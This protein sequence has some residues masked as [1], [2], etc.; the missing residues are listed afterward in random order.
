MSAKRSKTVCRVLWFDE[1]GR[2]TKAPKR[3][4][5][6]KSLKPKLGA[7]RKATQKIRVDGGGVATVRYM[8]S[9]VAVRYIPPADVRAEAKKRKADKEYQQQYREWIKNVQRELAADANAQ[10][11]LMLSRKHAAIMEKELLRDRGRKG[12]RERAKSREIQKGMK[13]LS[14]SEL[15]QKLKRGNVYEKRAARAELKARGVQ[16]G[17]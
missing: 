4:D 12:A 17:R 13:G 11:R 2:F 7:S 3:P 15:L 6:S 14:Q 1:K 10:R 16:V 9:G 8:K 5:Q